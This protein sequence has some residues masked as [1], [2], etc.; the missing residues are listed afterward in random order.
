MVLAG[1]TCVNIWAHYKEHRTQAPNRGLVHQLQGSAATTKLKVRFKRT[2][3]SIK[4]L[5]LTC[6]TL[7]T[8]NYHAS[9]GS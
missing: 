1:A 3:L 8:A 4:N 5:I 6:A 9:N 7:I 2:C